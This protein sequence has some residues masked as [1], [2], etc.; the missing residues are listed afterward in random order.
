MLSRWACWQFAVPR[1]L[2]VVVA[3][4]AAQYGLGIA[5]RAY[6]ARSGEAVI[7][8]KI[9][10]LHSRVSPLEGQLV[11]SGICVA[12][13]CDPTQNMAEADRCVLNFATASLLRKQ[14]V[15]ESGEIAGLRFGTSR[16][17]SDAL[18][19]VS[20]KTA[21]STTPWFGNDAGGVAASWLDRVSEQFRPGR[22]AQLPSLQLTE[23]LLTRSSSESASLRERM[24]DLK[25]RSSEMQRQVEE[26]QSNRL[27]HTKFLETLPEELASLNKEFDQ[28]TA[29]IEQLP[30]TL[31]EDRRAIVA[32][33]R[34]DERFVRDQMRMENVDANALSTY[35]LREQATAPLDEIISWLRWTRAIV[36]AARDGQMLGLAAARGENV[37]FSGCT[38]QPDWL[39]RNLNLQG[40]TRIGG[41]P[42][43]LRGTLSEM[44][45]DQSLHTVPLRLKLATTGSLPLVL[46]ATLDR[47]DGVA[48]DELIIDC[49]GIVI[50][51]LGLGEEER[52]R[53]S[54][55]PSVGTLNASIMLDGDKLTGE[56]QLVQ[57]E[58]AITPTMEGELSRT[59]LSASLQDTLGDV[60]SFA[61]RLSVRGTL[62]EPTCTLWSNLGPA[63]AES[64]DRALVR[65]SDK[66]CRELLTDAER[67]VDEQL[68]QLDRQMADSRSE[69]LP[70]LATLSAR[71]EQ[72]ADQQSTPSRLN[73][74][75]LGRRLPSNSLFR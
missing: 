18:T 28:L 15:V 69:L 72:I 52:L 48:R 13:T 34:D 51:K 49:R 43:E 17:A 16:C 41:Q 50:P 30:G 12:D 29:E 55:T 44:A 37:L 1:V 40:T 53:L 38:R 73:T 47:T 22:I 27:R 3:L 31:E 74:E 10:V 58:V 20:G 54:L 39:I 61:T 65:A 36:P 24:Q 26:A 8:G 60:H 33:R 6:V 5:V 57:K 2:T 25:R 42:L 71:L 21:T 67:R 45:A 32:A 70:Q 7:G 64:M 59:Q 23:K 75:Y 46:Q 14:V 68:A 4:L 66:H 56:I 62:T 9:E 11:L 35:L 63:V 19:S